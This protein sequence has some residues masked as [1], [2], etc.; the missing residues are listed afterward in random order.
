MEFMLYPTLE[1]SKGGVLP[2][3]TLPMNFKELVPKF[4]EQGRK[5]DIETYSEQLMKNLKSAFP[6]SAGE[7][8]IMLLWDDILGLK[9]I[10]LGVSVGLDLQPEGMFPK[11]I[12]HNLYTFTS[13]VGFA[14][15]TKY[16]SE[17]LKSE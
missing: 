9:N 17:L 15:A 13:I 7:L 4:Y 5:K 10:K 2:N 14:V 3:V 11:F 8:E 16:V 1:P 6:K 12:G